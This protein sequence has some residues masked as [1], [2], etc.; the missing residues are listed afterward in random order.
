MKLRACPKCA[1]MLNYKK[2]KDL[3][4]AQKLEKKHKKSHK[5]IQCKLKITI[6][7]SQLVSIFL[8]CDYYLKFGLTL[9]A[10]G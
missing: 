8:S 9:F 1:I 10:F 2:L 7:V 4:K 5:N 3:E 6:W